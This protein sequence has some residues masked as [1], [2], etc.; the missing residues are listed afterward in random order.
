M[1]SFPTPKTLHP[2]PMAQLL[3][4]TQHP[5]EADLALAFLQPM[6]CGPSVVETSRHPWLAIPS[7]STSL[8]A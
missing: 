5:A 8:V 4:P 2:S 6:A 3:E 1:Q 7:P